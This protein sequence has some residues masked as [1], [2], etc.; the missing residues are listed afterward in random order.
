MA[1]LVCAAI[2][3]FLLMGGTPLAR[4]TAPIDRHARTAAASQ[5]LNEYEFSRVDEVTENHIIGRGVAS[6]SVSG[7]GSTVM[8]LLNATQAAGE[9]TSGDAPNTITVKFTAIYWITGKL[10]H[11][12]G[13]VTSVRGRGKYASAVG[14]DVKFRGTMNRVKFTMNMEATGEW[15]P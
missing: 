2:V 10:A 9:F 7:L 4:A 6:G 14:K 8:N 12:H 13:T 1:A 15:R 3:M 11:F 5:P